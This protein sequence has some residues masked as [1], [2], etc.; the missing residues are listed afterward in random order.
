MPDTNRWQDAAQDEVHTQVFSYVGEV[1]SAQ[2]DIFDR[3]LRYACLYDPHNRMGFTGGWWTGAS[4]ATGSVPPGFEGL[5]SENVVASNVD[6]VAAIISRAQPRVRFMTDD[7]DWSTQRTAR[8]LEWYAEGLMKLLD[9][10]TLAQRAF[11]DAAIFGTGLLK[12][13]E[14]GSN[15]CVERVLVDELVVDEGECKSGKPTQM[16]QRK[17]VDRDLLIDR[18]P[19]H[20]DVIRRAQ[21]D[22]GG[23]AGWTWW[24]DYRPIERNQVVVI[25]SWQLPVRGR[26]GRHTICVDG[27]TLLDESW[28]KPHFP[29]ARIVW[30][31]PTTGWYGV[32]LVS[33]IAGHQRVLNKLNWQIDRQIDQFAVPRTWVQMADAN[34]AV[35][36]INRLGTIGVYK[37]SIPET[38]FPPSVSAEQF[39]RLEDVKASSFEESGVSR[40]AA[41]SMKPAGIESAVAM[42][43]YKDTTTERFAIQEQA[44]ERLIL[45]TVWLV[46]GCAK[47]LGDR[48]PEVV[49]KSRVGTKRIR[50]RDVDM[51]ETRVSMAAASSLSRTPAGRTQTV[52]EWAQAGVVTQDEAR[53]LLQHPDLERA[54]SLYTAALEDVERCIEDVLDGDFLV[55]EPFQNLKMGVWRFQQAYLKARGDGAP[56][57]VLENLRTWTVQAAQI[58]NPPVTPPAPMGAAGPGMAPMGPGMQ[59]GL[60][61]AQP[62]LGMLPPPGPEAPIQ[63]AFAPNAMELRPRAMPA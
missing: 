40:L 16:H 18:F 47:D 21:T 11:K 12:V 63:P 4:V 2:S 52:I 41:A 1:E 29:F 55:P 23:S 26:K 36:T 61:G 20:E 48:A 58:L 15:I 43:E 53:R 17:L 9:I 22:G 31:E 42:R 54:M 45:D 62:P 28:S 30:S 57:D 32:G 6:T 39:K 3:F 34:I 10:P 51:A 56:E 59:P 50:W 24:A 33:R 35:R 19:E 5:V 13:F 44:Y 14:D 49:R 37:G 25:E 46:L 7:G 27:A 38:Q 8:R 60:P